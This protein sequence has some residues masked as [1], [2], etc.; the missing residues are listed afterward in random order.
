[1][2][3]M[4]Q[5]ENRCAQRSPRGEVLP[6]APAPRSAAIDLTYERQRHGGFVGREALLR[7]LDQ[8]LIHELAQRRVVVTRGPETGKSAVLAVWMDRREVVGDR[9]PH[10]FIRRGWSNWDDPE[11][12]VVS[13]IAQVE[14]RC[15]DAREPDADAL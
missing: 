10:H 8:Q 15:S 1:M 9:V 13:L 4:G 7:Q 14:A 2:A 3:S 6:E 5:D 11:A 12:L